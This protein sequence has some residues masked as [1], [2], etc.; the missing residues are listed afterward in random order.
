VND[1]ETFETGYGQIEILNERV[2]DD[3]ELDFIDTTLDGKG[4]RVF[5]ANVKNL[6]KKRAVSVRY[7]VEWFNEEGVLMSHDPQV[8]RLTIRPRDT[9]YI[10]VETHSHD[11]TYRV[12]LM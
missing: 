6:N 11:Y 4:T 10:Y 9:R 12:V 3:V 2:T 7:R 5:Q 1:V 8:K